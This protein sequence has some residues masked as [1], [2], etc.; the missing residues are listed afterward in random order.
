MLRRPSHPLLLAVVRKKAGPQGTPDEMTAEDSESR[1]TSSDNTRPHRVRH[2]DVKTVARTCVFTHSINTG[3][4]NRSHS[5]Q[6][7]IV[8]TRTLTV[9]EV[10]S[11]SMFRADDNQTYVLRGVPDT[12]DDHP[13]FEEA[14]TFVEGRILNVELRIDIGTIHELVD[15]EALQVDAYDTASKL[16]NVPLAAH[17]DGIYVGYPIIDTTKH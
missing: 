11:P 12:D 2:T 16:L 4:I 9:K 1:N 13:H 15:E 8:E 5:T 14:R 7:A 17:V 6:E 10:L 3:K